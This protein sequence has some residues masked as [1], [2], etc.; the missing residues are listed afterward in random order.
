VGG[1]Q[2]G[3][4]VFNLIPEG[5][6]NGSV[7]STTNIYHPVTGDVSEEPIE[8]VGF[9]DEKNNFVKIPFPVNDNGV[10]KIIPLYSWTEGNPRTINIPLSIK[11]H[12]Q[13]T[14]MTH[15]HPRGMALSEGDINTA[16]LL[17]LKGI[18]ARLNRNYFWDNIESID[19]NKKDVIYF[20]NQL[21]KDM[22]GD[23]NSLGI[24]N[25]INYFVNNELKINPNRPQMVSQAAKKN[26]RWQKMNSNQEERKIAATNIYQRL[27]E[28]T[29]LPSS[30]VSYL[31]THAN[32]KDLA[33]KYNYD[34]GV[35]EA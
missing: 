32:M 10:E 31:V 19:R 12:V 6:R 2:T 18:E 26:D 30:A 22:Q 17:N 35:F 9:L 1:N 13:N 14:V 27:F 23:K 16:L 4:N 33:S 7:F 15:N 34:Y 29:S 5:Q 11:K 20:V 3:V 24:L 25:Q 28:E 8:I 21:K